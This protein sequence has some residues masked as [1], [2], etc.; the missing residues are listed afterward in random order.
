MPDTSL[1]KRTSTTHLA[2]DDLSKLVRV[3]VSETMQEPCQHRT[4]IS[5]LCLNTAQQCPE[6][7]ANQHQSGG[8]QLQEFRRMSCRCCV[9][10]LPLCGLWACCGFE[11]IY[12]SHCQCPKTLSMSN[13]HCVD[14]VKEPH[15]CEGIQPATVP[16]GV[17]LPPN[18]CFFI[19]WY[20]VVE[21]KFYIVYNVLTG[22]GQL[23]LAYDL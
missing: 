11:L 14:V 2:D 10:D 9:N 18:Y 19:I 7:S 3:G 20:C 12:C 23:V 16:R 21:H 6:G 1:G 13:K 8:G 15:Y 4:R 17:L 22:K 5:R